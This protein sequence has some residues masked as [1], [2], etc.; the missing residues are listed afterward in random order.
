MNIFVYLRR[1]CSS[2][3]ICSARKVLFLSFQFLCFSVDNFVTKHLFLSKLNF[4]FILFVFII[5]L[6]LIK[7]VHSFIL[8]LK[9]IS[10][11]KHDEIQLSNWATNLPRAHNLK[12]LEK[13]K[14][15]KSF[16]KYLSRSVKVPK[17]HFSFGDTS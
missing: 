6:K 11:Y 9:W 2:Q 17:R 5:Y 7:T 13:F 14:N 12:E 4:Y 15:L 8:F 10:S 1:F 16:M 3:M